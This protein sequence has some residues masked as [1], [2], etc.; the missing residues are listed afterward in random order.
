[1]AR[2]PLTPEQEAAKWV[3]SLPDEFIECRANTK[4]NFV[5]LHPMHD[6]ERRDELGKRRD[7]VQEDL[8]CT[9]CEKQRHDYFIRHAVG[10]GARRIVRL[11]K[12]YA[13]YSDPVGYAKPKHVAGD[14][15]MNE[16]IYGE[17]YRRAMQLVARTKVPDHLVDAPDS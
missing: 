14:V 6:V 7:W 11:V 2:K 5:T 15:R 16:L 8:I 4:H 9:R 10:G 12:Q 1:M 17:K 13:R 3:Q